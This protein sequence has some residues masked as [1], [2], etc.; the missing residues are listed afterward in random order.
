[1]TSTIGPN[2]AWSNFYTQPIRREKD[3]ITIQHTKNRLEIGVLSRINLCTTQEIQ[4]CNLN[5][6][7]CLVPRLLVPDD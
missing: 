1:M 5:C 2:D 6:P 3:N 4:K 7:P